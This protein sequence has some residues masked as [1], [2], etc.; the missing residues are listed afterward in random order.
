M[1]A[2]PTLTGLATVPPSPCPTSSPVTT[3]PTAKSSPR[4]TRAWGPT[5]SRTSLPNC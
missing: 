1:T 3:T 2:S 4:S 5:G